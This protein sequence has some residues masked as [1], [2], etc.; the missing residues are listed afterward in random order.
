MGYQFIKLGKPNPIKVKVQEKAYSAFRKA[1]KC[2][3]H[4]RKTAIVGVAGLFIFSLLTL[5]LVNR[6]FFPPSVRPEII[7]DVNLPSGASIKDTKKVM[8][9][10]ADSLYGDQR[11]SSF[12][13][14]I[15]DTAPRFILLFSPQAAEDDHGQMII[16]AR[17][18]T[19][20]DSLQ[21]DVQ[22][23]LADSYPEVRAHTRFIQTGPLEEYPVMLRLRG[24]DAGKTAALAEEALALMKQNPHVTNASLDWPQQT[25]TVHLKINQD[26]VRE[27]GID[28][29]AVSQDLYVKLSGYKVAESYQGD[30]LVPISFRLEGDNAARLGS[31]SSLPVYAG[32]GRYVPLGEFADI[33]YQNETST[34]WRR[35]IEPCITLRSDITGDA[36]S[37]TVA[38]SVYD[39]TLKDFRNNLPEGYTLEKAALWN[40]ATFP[41]DRSWLPCRL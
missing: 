1:V 16:V 8:S 11:V 40:E 36:T 19:A 31:L 5:P 32:N 37:D 28:N 9:A 3:I 23:F 24:P 25:P 12:S 38:S 35:N 22:K 6:E 33:S 18:T 2:F 20:R 13:T 26:K 29:Y 21:K 27:L 7:L 15:G 30:Q 14:Y 34:I 39:K 10:V 41:W 17:D 4:Y